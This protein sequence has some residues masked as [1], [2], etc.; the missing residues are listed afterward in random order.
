MHTK[1]C[2]CKVNI[3]S[4]YNVSYILQLVEKKRVVVAKLKCRLTKK[5]QVCLIGN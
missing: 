5:E 4:I 3:E 1:G 2:L